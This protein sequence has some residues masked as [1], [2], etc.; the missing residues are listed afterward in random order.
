MRCLCVSC[1]DYYD[2]KMRHVIKFLKEQ[3]HDVL[4]AVADFDH[5]TKEYRKDKRNDTEYLHV[6]KYAKNLS[7]ARLASHSGFA[8]KAYALAKKYKP[9]MIYCMFPPNSLV[10][11]KSVI[12]L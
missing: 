5:Y 12:I 9:H 8:K 2:T 4:Y 3:G 11:L 10:K 7:V 6:K 1:F